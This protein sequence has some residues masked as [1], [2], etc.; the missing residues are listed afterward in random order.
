MTMKEIH[1]K[2]NKREFIVIKDLKVL[3]NEKELMERVNELA[4]QIEK[5]YLDEEI[6]LICILKGAVYFTTDLS[7]RINNNKVV[8]DFMKVSSYG[9]ATETSGKVDFQLDLSE[10]IKGRNV[11][12]VEDILDSGV[13]LHYLI[14]ILS[15][16][17]PKSIKICTL[18]DKPERRRKQV[19]VD[20]VGFE[21]KD[22]FVVGYGMDYNEHYR[23]L[24]YIGYFE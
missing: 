4:N 14:N 17:N 10:D 21:I 20:Y 8:L 3:I 7:K 19:K 13:T 16:R 12:I 15:K 1:G 2:Q 23:N 24:P 11:I 22:K 6:I 5:D 18:L 9:S